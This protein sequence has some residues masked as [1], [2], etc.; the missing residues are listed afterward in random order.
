MRHRGSR[1]YIFPDIPS[2]FEQLRSPKYKLQRVRQED[3]DIKVIKAS[4]VFEHWNLHA[5][6]SRGLF[7]F[8]IPGID[9]A[10]DTE[11]RIVR[12]HAVQTLR[13]FISAVGDRYLA[14]VERIANADAAAVMKRNPTGAACCVE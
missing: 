6:L 13:S 10:G 3:D 1:L 7:R 5:F 8:F 4:S 11:A 12:E 14:G 2:C 9:V